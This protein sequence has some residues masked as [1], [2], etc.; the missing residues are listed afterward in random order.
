MQE[1]LVRGIE[2]RDVVARHR[3]EVQQRKKLALRNLTVGSKALGQMKRSHC[4]G[5][6][7]KENSG[8]GSLHLGSKS[9]NCVR[10]I[11][12]YSLWQ[13]LWVF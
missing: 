3:E 6:N 7:G 2:G 5:K 13:H 11:V 9:L 10:K 1:C 12:L 4:E 8:T